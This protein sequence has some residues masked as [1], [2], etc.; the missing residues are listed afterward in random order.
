MGQIRKNYIEKV[1]RELIVIDMT[2]DPFDLTSAFDRSIG[3]A[4]MARGINSEGDVLTQTLDGRPLNDLWT[5]FQRTMA[6][7]N[8]RR[9][10]LINLLTFPVTS[11]TEQVPQITGDDFE[12]AS[13]YGEPK[14]LALTPDYFSMGYD[15]KWYD[16][17]IRYSWK[18]LAEVNAAQVVAL[19]NAAIE[20]D[21]RLLFV[22]IFKAIFNNTNRTTDIR[23][24]NYNVYPF[25]NG[26]GTVPPTYINYTY[27]G[28]ESH[29][30][31]SGGATV[32]S[33]DLDAI[34]TKLATKGYGV[35]NGSKLVLLANRQEIATMRTFRVAT[36]SNYDFIP[37]QGAPP[38]L[39]PQNV[40][41]IQG[42]Q[43]AA[44]Y[45]G[46]TVAGSYGPFTIIDNDY[47]PAGYL[48]AFATGGELNATNPV[49]LREHVNAGLRGLRLVKGRDNDYP[50]VDSFYN[51][52][53]G[54]GVRHRGAGVVM[55]IKASGSY[56]IPTA[57][58]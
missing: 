48:L 6:M 20:A 45:Q 58:V 53:F 50:L 49:G 13:E 33:G 40:G 43:P 2:Q 34:E 25:Y 41:G 10:A 44:T 42:G 15:F 37:A 24:T 51:H 8:A 36:G 12:E 57:Y 26:D 46:L 38:F 30:L 9:T 28:S 22:K 4:G 47:I 1:E 14:G 32:D 21:N 54:T 11:P 56:V 3:L 19:N 5:E 17:A 7:A 16:L 18:F 31:V 27:N 39:F 29:Y 55:Q 23:G 52:G 35:T